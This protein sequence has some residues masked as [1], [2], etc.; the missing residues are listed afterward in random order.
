MRAL[1]GVTVL[2]VLAAGAACVLLL[3]AKQPSASLRD[4][5]VPVRADRFD[6]PAAWRLIERQLRYGQR[7]AGSPQLR[8]LSAKLVRKMPHGHFERVPG[9]GLRNVVGRVPGRRPALLIGAHYDT[10]AAPKGF[11]GANNG[12]AGSA[13]VVQLARD[14]SRLRRPDGA[15]AITFV[16]FDCEEPAEGLPEDADDFYA[17]GLRG[18]RAYVR[19]HRG[20]VATMVLLDYVANRGLKLPREGS[21]SPQVWREIRAASHAVGVGAVFPDSTQTTILDDHTPFLRAGIPAVDLI[22]WS[23]DGHSPADT[24]D[25][26]S[27]RSV[28]AVGETLI[29]FARELDRA[30]ATP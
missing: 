29:E 11:V 12:A 20:G 15:R 9:K 26:L 8:A 18:S 6:A 14:L 4:E 27:L 25:K 24:L 1:Y 22:D 13:I 23:Y 16:L 2:V 30:A 5:V 7:P 21:S 17:Q 10:L 3:G 19:A 28:D